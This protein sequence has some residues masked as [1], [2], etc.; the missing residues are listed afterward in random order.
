MCSVALYQ[1]PKRK[2]EFFNQPCPEKIQKIRTFLEFK[3]NFFN[4]YIR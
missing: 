1:G 2:P 4:Y 3:K